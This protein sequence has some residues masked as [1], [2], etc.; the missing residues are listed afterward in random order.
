MWYVDAR[1]QVRLGQIVTVWTVHVSH[2]EQASLAPSTAPLFTSIFPEREQSCHLEI[3]KNGDDGTMYKNPYGYNNGTEP[4]PGLMTLKNFTE[5]GYGV[6]D[7][8]LLVCVKSIGAKKR[9]KTERRILDRVL[10][11][12]QSPRRPV[13][14]PNLSALVFSTTQP[15]QSSHCAVQCAAQ[16]QFGSHQRLFC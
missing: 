9:C 12:V 3:Q 11:C 8:K 4:M 16:L 15:K 5:G 1:Y 7:C 2:G 10:T 14:P 13:T 6:D